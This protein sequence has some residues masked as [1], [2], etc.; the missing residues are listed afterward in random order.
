VPFTRAQGLA[1]GLSVGDLRGSRFRRL[2]H[3]TYVPADRLLT[4]ALLAEVALRIAPPGAVAARHTA[5]V[6]WGGVVPDTA[7]VHLALKPGTRLRVDGIDARVRHRVQ[8]GRHQGLPLTSPGQTF[9]DLAEDLDLVDLVVVGDSLVPSGLVSLANLERAATQLSGPGTKG[10]GRAVAYVR[11][12]VDSAMESR[13]RLLLVLAGLPEPI[14]N[15][16]IRDEV[17]GRVLYRI[18]LAY[19]AMEDRHRIRRS[20]ARRVRPSVAMGRPAPRRAGTGRLAAR[21]RVVR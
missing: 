16:P 7:Q 19:P 10:A 17:T 8:M 12:G 14:V 18:D 2:V 13:L 21:R 5:A 15:L 3:D 11:P 9:H 6:L 4:T 20:T 1:A